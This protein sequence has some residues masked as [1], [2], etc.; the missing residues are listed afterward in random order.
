MGLYEVRGATCGQSELDCK[1]TKY[2]KD[3][4]KGL[5]DGKCADQG[6]TKQTGTKT[7]HVPVVG[8]ITITEYSSRTRARYT[9]SV[10]P[11]VASRNSIV[12]TPNMRG[13]SRKG[14]KTVN[15]RI[16]ATQSKQVRKQCTSQS[17][18]TSLSQSTAKPVLLSF[19]F[20]S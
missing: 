16:R 14:C 2:A 18:A 13:N 19:E 17:L 10:V 12:N 1:Y 7:M 4:Q 11:R 3:F 5:Q 15:A 8:D 6:Y 20:C 9:K